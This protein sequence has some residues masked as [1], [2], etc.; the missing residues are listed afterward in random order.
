[1]ESGKVNTRLVLNLRDGIIEA[2][3]EEN[4]VRS[5][6]D[7]F[8]E[9]VS[10]TVPL[11]T[12]PR[13]VLETRAD[14]TG[15]PES[16]S[17]KK[18]RKARSAEGGKPKASDYK[19]AFDSKLDLRE[20][21]QFYDRFEPENNFEKILIFAV[22]LRD[23]LNVAPCTADA[24]YSCYFVLKHKTKIPVAFVQAFRDAQ[25]RTHYIE[26]VSPE[27][28]DITIAGDNHF[29]QRLKRKGTSE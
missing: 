13:Q 5:I 27:K 10:K 15:Q 24:V 20:L 28:I 1:M 26:F 16:E 4:F 9:R 7:D 8:K 19:P 21:E 22:F 18:A 11:Q 25:S 17:K 23:T 12:M 2:E 29:N 6:Y 14:F 3:G